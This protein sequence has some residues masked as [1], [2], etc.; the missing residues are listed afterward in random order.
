MSKLS[1][2]PRSQKNSKYPRSLCNATKRASPV[3]IEFED[4]NF[5]RCFFTRSSVDARAFDFNGSLGVKVNASH[6]FPFIN[7][8]AQITAKKFPARLWCCWASSSFQVFRGRTFVQNATNAFDLE[9]TSLDWGFLPFPVDS[10]ANR[11]RRE[12]RLKVHKHITP[13]ESFSL[14]LHSSNG[15]FNFFLS[16]FIVDQEHIWSGRFG[17]DKSRK[18]N[19]AV[20]GGVGEFS[21]ELVRQHFFMCKAKASSNPIKHDWNWTVTSSSNNPEAL[22]RFC[23]RMKKY[24]VVIQKS[25]NLHKT[26]EETVREL[27]FINFW[28]G[29]KF[30]VYQHRKKII[31]NY[32]NVTCRKQKRASSGF[33]TI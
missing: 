31:M 6:C 25:K 14:F 19:S 28:E 1:L 15:F 11:C 16:P 27:K 24:K 8:K 20:C 23:A 22:H 21:H 3:S 33:L 32:R 4:R 17:R 2:H 7:F 29:K 26:K 9:S 30:F 5:H 12:K 18:F 10:I 13:Q